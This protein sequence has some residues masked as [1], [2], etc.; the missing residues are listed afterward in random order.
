M[1][2]FTALNI[3]GWIVVGVTLVVTLLLVL[4]VLVSWLSYNYYGWLQYHLRQI[5][6]PMVRP[7][8][9]GFGTAYSRYDLMPLVM[10]ALVLL[11]GYF[12]AVTV[13]RFS[14]TSHDFLYTLWYG[15]PSAM[16][17][18]RVTFRFIGCLYIIAF[19]LRFV[20][21]W[22]GVGYRNPLLRFVYTVTEP[23]LRPLRKWCMV[24]MFD[25]SWMVAIFLVDLAIR[26]IAP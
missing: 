18:F 3:V 13:W 17:L 21:P 23:L 26:L 10:A 12:V 6:E 5:T 25:L 16:F 14:S 15:T 19:M 22:M 8:R 4:R 9:G 11:N 1:L 24:G 20:L 7:L 2:F